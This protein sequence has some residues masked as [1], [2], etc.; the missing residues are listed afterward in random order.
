MLP[1]VVQFTVNFINKVKVKQGGMVAQ[2][3][4]QKFVSNEVT[5]KGKKT[6][7]QAVLMYLRFSCWS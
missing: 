4:A 6:V 2:I 3:I 1:V 5:Q 7:R